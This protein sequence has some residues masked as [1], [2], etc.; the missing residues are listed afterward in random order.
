MVVIDPIESDI[1]ATF[2]VEVSISP[3]FNQT[4]YTLVVTESSPDH[5]TVLLGGVPMEM[6][7]STVRALYI[8]F[9]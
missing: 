1:N 5:P 9:S 7:S 3:L 2:T 8:Y 4:E 6:Y